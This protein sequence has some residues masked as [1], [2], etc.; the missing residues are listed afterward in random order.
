MS[1]G[2]VSSPKLKQGRLAACGDGRRVEQHLDGGVPDSLR[3]LGG[4][5]PRKPLLL[6]MGTDRQAEIR[7]FPRYCP[8][9]PVIAS[10]RP[11]AGTRAGDPARLKVALLG[12]DA[13]N[14]RQSRVS[15][16]QRE[17]SECAN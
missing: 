15:R 2:I 10:S 14:G 17:S 11:S 16:R 3:H 9:R 13:N 6:Y 12:P 8:A 5:V 4:Y 7:I 1:W